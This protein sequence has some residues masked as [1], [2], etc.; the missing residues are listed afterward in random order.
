M[1]FKNTD[2]QIMWV[3]KRVFIYSLLRGIDLL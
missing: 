3:L 1:R 2:S